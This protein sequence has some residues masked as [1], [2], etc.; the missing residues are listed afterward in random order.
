MESFKRILIFEPEALGHQSDYIRLLISYLSEQ[1][2]ALKLTL[3]VSST[4]FERLRVTEETS[5]R[6]EREE[7]KFMTL[8][9]RE[10]C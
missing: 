2:L 3:L 5:Q 1:H 8:T 9:E 10:S 6:I 7:I 4:L